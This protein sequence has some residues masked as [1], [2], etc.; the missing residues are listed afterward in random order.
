MP[1][2][3][4][5]TLATGRPKG[6]A[7]SETKQLRKYLA[8]VIEDNKDKFLKELNKLEGRDYVN[9]FQNLLE[10][11]TPKMQRTELRGEVRTTTTEIFKIGDQEIEFTSSN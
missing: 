11:C 10:Y 7:N 6:S 9:A 1:F 2:T 5:H 3:K 4:G 8:L